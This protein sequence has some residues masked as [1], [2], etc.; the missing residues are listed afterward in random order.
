M[1]D[2]F[3]DYPEPSSLPELSSNQQDSSL[4]AKFLP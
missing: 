2:C 3:T 4:I 1:S